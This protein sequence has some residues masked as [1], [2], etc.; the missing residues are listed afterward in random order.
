VGRRP[1]GP[2]TP[3]SGGVGSLRSHFSPVSGCVY[4]RPQIRSV[5]AIR[6][7]DPQGA[8]AIALLREAALDARELYPELYPPGSPLPSNSP[9]PERGVYVVAYAGDRPLACGAIQ[10]YE[11]VVAEVRRMYV[12]RE[13]RRRGLAQAVL[14]HLVGRARELGYARIVLETGYKQVEAMRFY[15]AAGFRRI[16]SF[17]KYAD[18]PTSVCYELLISEA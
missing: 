6:D 13:H 2:S 4:L 7:V 17:G 16:A 8:D 1:T 11:A 15:E 9:L 18:D 10:P 5:L 3:T 14:S 12:H